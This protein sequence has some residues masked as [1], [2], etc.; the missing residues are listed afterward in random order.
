MNNS[1]ALPAWL[2]RLAGVLPYLFLLGA[3]YSVFAET[4]DDPYITFRYAAH[5][6]AGQGPVFNIGERVEGYTSPLHLLLSAF[7]LILAPSLDI[8]FKA[9]CASLLFGL[10]MLAQTGMLAR[11]C[12]L[13]GWEALLAQSLVAL[14]INFALASVNALETTL[15]G[16]VLLACLLQFHRECRSGRGLISAL[17]FFAATLARP[18]AVL[19]VAALLIVRLLWLHRRQ[20]PLQFALGWLLMFLV[21]SAFFEI[22]RWNYY[23]QLLPNTY[24]AKAQPL[25]QSL[26]SGISYPLRAMSPTPTVIHTF[27]LHL[28]L[29]GSHDFFAF[30]SLAQK[31]LRSDLFNLFMPLL[32]WG[33]AVLGLWRIKWRLLGNISLAVIVAVLVFVLKAGG[34]WM[35]GWRFMAPILPLLA[36]CQCHGIRALSRYRRP[37]SVLSTRLCGAFIAALWLISC[38]KTNHYS[39]KSA[40]FS[41]HGSHLLQASEGYG[42]LWVKGADYIQQLP[43]GATVAYSEMGYAGFSNMDKSLLDIRGL[44]DR[45]IAHLPA[46]YKYS[47]GIADKNWYQQGDPLGQILQQRKPSVI[48]SFDAVP[49][50][51][52]LGGY[53]RAGVLPL[54]TNDTQG[55]T[56]AFVYRRQTS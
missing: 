43:P 36:I 15:Y 2:L 50:N 17:L 3:A 53:Q 23:G 35:Y 12:G 11:R 25:I 40:N 31:N 20:L 30:H 44:T 42:P 46:K 13:R 47:T 49:P 54:P 28:S 27:L 48:I 37:A 34:D 22:A 14:N 55:S 16:A 6:L 24:F 52:A 18:E 4:V 5:L 45:E 9:K 39:W 1:K 38:A 29:L 7:L 10:V 21:P 51:I 26:S 33:L 19:V 56:Y 41:T 8:L 32:F